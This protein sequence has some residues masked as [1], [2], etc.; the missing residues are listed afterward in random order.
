MNECRRECNTPPSRP[1]ASRSALNALESVHLPPPPICGNIPTSPMGTV[2][3]LL[4][5]S[6]AQA[7][8]TD[9]PSKSM[10][11][12]FQSV[13]IA[14][15]A[16]ILLISGCSSG[17]STGV[18][19]SKQTVTEKQ[20]F[21]EY[22]SFYGDLHD[23]LINV[24]DFKFTNGFVFGNP[25]ATYDYDVFNDPES[26]IVFHVTSSFGKDHY[27]RTGAIEGRQLPY[28][29]ERFLRPHPRCFHDYL[30][31]QGSEVVNFDFSQD[32]LDAIGEM[33]AI[34]GVIKNESTT[35][36]ASGYHHW[37]KH[38]R[39]EGRAIP[40]NTDRSCKGMITHQP[41]CRA[42]S[43]FPNC[44]DNKLLGGSLGAALAEA[45]AAAQACALR[46][47]ALNTDTNQC[48]VPEE[49]AAGPVTECK[50]GSV[51]INGVPNGEEC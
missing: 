30:V 13:V 2:T 3:G 20:C 29:C 47:G 25:F 33:N 24:E 41:A 35:A 7:L 5:F 15:F 4:Y 11:R 19:F 40:T 34:H 36:P 45:A 16:S 31:L 32:H 51:L 38:G 28:G 1:T 8:A 12:S 6:L 46:G 44:N 27:H 9:Q 21:A 49:E 42:G 10:N 23:D 48:T 26:E 22:V 18:S 50:N 17:S 14:F 39:D 37:I 43:R